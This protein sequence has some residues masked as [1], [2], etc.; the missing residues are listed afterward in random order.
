MSITAR[1]AVKC[2]VNASSS[3]ANNEEVGPLH[4]ALAAARSA[5]L[6]IEICIAAELYKLIG[7]TKGSFSAK[8]FLRP[9]HLPLMLLCT[10]AAFSRRR[11]WPMGEFA[12][13]ICA[14]YAT[15][16]DRPAWRPPQYI[17]NAYAQR[18]MY[19]RKKC[20]QPPAVE[21]G[22]E[23]SAAASSGRHGALSEV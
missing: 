12:I 11:N 13:K 7:R 1:Q 2:S 4:L 21:A 6:G 10:F 5:L 22:R 3:S 23:I 19:R 14:G 8:Y 15:T 18:G 17:V 9:H 20:M 16:T